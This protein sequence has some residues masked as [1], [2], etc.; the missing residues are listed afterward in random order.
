[1]DIVQV[2]Q[3]A[4]KDC[5]IGSPYSK[6]DLINSGTW[7]QLK[8]RIH[9]ER[10][11]F[12][13]MVHYNLKSDFIDDLDE[14]RAGEVV[15]NGAEWK[16]YFHTA[17]KVIAKVVRNYLGLDADNRYYHDPIDGSLYLVNSG[18]AFQIHKL[19]KPNYT[20]PSSAVFAYLDQMRILDEDVEVYIQFGKVKLVTKSVTLYTEMTESEFC[21]QYGDALE[22]A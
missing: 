20:L 9:D 7:F 1:M 12:C 16:T 15:L 2:V 13:Y 11:E 4:F 8:D 10:Q 6:F 18:Y 5:G 21:A 3:K 22:C 17:Q 14:I 19:V